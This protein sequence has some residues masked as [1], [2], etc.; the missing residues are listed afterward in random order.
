M[1]V[2]PSYCYEEKEKAE[3]LE[4]CVGLDTCYGVLAVWI[5]A[6][7]IMAATCGEL[8]MAYGMMVSRT[9]IWC[10]GSFVA[11]CVHEKEWLVRSC[12]LE[13]SWLKF[14]AH[15]SLP[16]FHFLQVFL[17]VIWT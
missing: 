10:C 8:V 12:P 11:H 2:P 4:A 1:K 5:G 7:D 14:W 9:Y 6:P 3:C 16:Y 15:G 17:I 13:N